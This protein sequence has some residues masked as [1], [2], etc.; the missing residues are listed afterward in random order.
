MTSEKTNP[1]S[2]CCESTWDTELEL[3]LPLMGRVENLSV[4]NWPCQGRC[5]F[6]D[7]AGGDAPLGLMGE[8]HGSK[9]PAVGERTKHV[10]AFAVRRLQ[11]Q[12]AHRSESCKDN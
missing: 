7:K 12:D 9:A 4:E 11:R 2:A 10:V 3:L 1:V 5:S 8:V 6:H